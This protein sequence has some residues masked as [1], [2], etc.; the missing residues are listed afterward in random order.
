MNEYE[1][2]ETLNSTYEVDREGKR[3]RRV[4][5]VNP[6]T[7]NQGT[8]GEWKD[9]LYLEDLPFGSL[10]IVWAEGGSTITSTR[11]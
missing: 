11:R 4:S 7:S 3:I 6:P 5:G 8:D 9:Y 2:F 10:H 1:V